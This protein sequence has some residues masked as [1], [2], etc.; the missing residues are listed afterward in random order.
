MPEKSAILILSWLLCFPGF[1]SFY[2]F[3]HD[4]WDEEAGSGEE[5]I[6]LV[7]DVLKPIGNGTYEAA[8][9]QL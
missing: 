9:S 4:C 1:Q 5:E 3:S 2:C 6:L 8:L 7:T